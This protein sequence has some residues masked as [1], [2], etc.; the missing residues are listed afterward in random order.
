MLNS[1]EFVNITTFGIKG[2]QNI[3]SF[4]V[5][6]DH[7]YSYNLYIASKSQVDICLREVA[8]M[9]LAGEGSLLF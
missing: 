5:I 4:F 3:K 1:T 6:L 9:H 8:E 2:H 7:K